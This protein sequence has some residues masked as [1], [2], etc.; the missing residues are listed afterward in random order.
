MKKIKLL[1]IFSIFF[2]SQT[3]SQ[4]N[5]E[6][7]VRLTNLTSCDLVLKKQKTESAFSRHRLSFGFTY[8]NL[9]GNHD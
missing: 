1:L 9:Y 7:G 4:V 3:F 8:L 6:I 2:T 5:K